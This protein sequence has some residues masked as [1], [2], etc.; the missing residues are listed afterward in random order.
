MSKIHFNDGVT[1]D[2]SG[3][4]RVL[5]LRDG[6][7]VVGEGWCIPVEDRD[8]ANKTIK[9]MKGDNNGKV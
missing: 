3:P 4:L 1:I 8:E 5:R 7:Y 6:F 2:T 9:D